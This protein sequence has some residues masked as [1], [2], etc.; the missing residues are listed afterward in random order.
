MLQAAKAQGKRLVTLSGDSHNGWFTYLTSLN[1]EK[2]GIEFVGTSVTSTGFESAGLG[3]LASSIDGSALV[4][5]LGN[6]AIGA[7]LG[8]IDD[9]AHCDTTRSRYLSMTFSLGEVKAQHVFVSSVK[10]PAYT[11]A[12][13]R[14]VTVPASAAGIAAPTIA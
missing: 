11:V 10:E 2:L 9:V 6:A 8:L 7:G 5:Q 1:Q 14:T 4:P 13:G 12:L 3:A